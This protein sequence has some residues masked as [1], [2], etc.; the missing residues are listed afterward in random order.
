MKVSNDTQRLEGNSLVLHKARFYVKK[1]SA[2][3]FKSQIGATIKKKHH[4]STNW[5]SA[6][7][8]SERR[9]RDVKTGAS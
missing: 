6:D 8:R 5:G 4:I 3:R 2:Y 1:H 9:R 7:S